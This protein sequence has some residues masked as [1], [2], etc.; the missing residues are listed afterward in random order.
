[1]GVAIAVLF[2]S[3]WTTNFLVVQKY[4]V[5]VKDLPPAFEGFTILHLSDLHSKEFGVGQE[6]LLNLINGQDFDLV[7]I[8][9][10]LVDKRNPDCEPGLRLVERLSHKPVYFVPGNHDWWTGFEYRHQL[11]E[12]GARIL[13]NQAEK[14]IWKGNHL[15]VIGVDDP[16]LGRDN[17]K[18]ALMEV[19]DTS[20]KILL[21]HAPNIYDS[22]I[23][24]EIDLVMVGHTHGGQVRLPVLGAIIA[25]GQGLF[26]KFDYGLFSSGHTAMIINGGLGE[27][28]LPIRFN[29]KPE[30][31]IITLHKM[32]RG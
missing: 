21:A 29:L 28:G 7:A 18:Q 5:S 26:P 1:M 2:Y 24:S 22:A 14:F 4:N 10:D 30:I 20:P 15:W 31:V 32:R 3:V 27:S 13:Q 8:T 17:L 19:D 11:E 25:P 16:Y 23:E 6:K 9:G 12:S